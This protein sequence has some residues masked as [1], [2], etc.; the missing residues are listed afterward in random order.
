MPELLGAGPPSGYT[1]TLYDLLSAYARQRQR[2]ALSA[3]TLPKRT[4]WSLAEARD[5]LFRL[6]GVAGEWT[7]IDQFL[8]EYVVEPAMRATVF[9]SSFSASL[10]MVREGRIEIQQES[11]FA[12]IWMRRTDSVGGKNGESN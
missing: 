9:A 1:A 3:V 4:V 2:Q 8:L 6:V 10:E 11:A 5:A 7:C 12:P